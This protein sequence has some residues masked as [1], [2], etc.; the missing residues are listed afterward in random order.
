VSEFLFN[1]STGHT[2]NLILSGDSRGT[3]DDKMKHP[4]NTDKMRRFTTYATNYTM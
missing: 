2:W 3:C 1:L 4:I